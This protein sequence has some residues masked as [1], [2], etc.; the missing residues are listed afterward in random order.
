[1]CRKICGEP[2][3]RGQCSC[4]A[5]LEKNCGPN[6]PSQNGTLFYGYS[7]IAHSTPFPLPSPD[8]DLAAFLLTRG[9]YAYFGYGWTGCRRRPPLY[10]AGLAGPRPRRPARL[11]RRDGA[12][13][14]RLDA[15]VRK[16]RRLARLRQVGGSLHAQVRP[17][18]RHWACAALPGRRGEVVGARAVRDAHTRSTW[19]ERETCTSTLKEEPPLSG[20]GVPQ[21][22]S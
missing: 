21:C 15:A 14:G 1:M 11:L 18:R 5:Y 4:A 19:R 17:R 20:M 7:R 8:Q 13:L 9:P 3:V 6:S 22:P 12:R 16:V 10:A 2:D